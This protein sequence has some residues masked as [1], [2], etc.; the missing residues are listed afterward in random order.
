MTLYMICVGLHLIAL[1]LWLGHM[2]VWSLIVGPAM[3]AIE[4]ASTAEELRSASLSGGGLG[5]PALVILIATGLYLLNQR[6][7]APAD[8][9]S[10]SAFAGTQGTILAVKL[11][12]VAAMVAFQAAFGHRSAAG[13][14]YVNILSAMIVVGASVVLVRGWIG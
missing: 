2:L 13:A 6:G 9:L 10:G 12:F 3:K 4:P 11:C 1:T 5:W 14:I 8:L 7:I